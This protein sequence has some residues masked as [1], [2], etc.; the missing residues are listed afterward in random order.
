MVAYSVAPMVYPVSHLRM[1]L[2]SQQSSL[3]KINWML[4][5]D[6]MNARF[7]PV[8]MDRNE[9]KVWIMMNPMPLQLFRLHFKKQPAHLLAMKMFKMVQ[10]RV[11]ASHKWQAL[12][13]KVLMHQDHGLCLQ[14]NCADPCFHT[15]MIDGP[16]VLISCATDDLLVSASCTVY[17]RI[18]ATM[19]GAGWKMHDKGLASFFFGIPICQSDDEWYLD[20][21][22]TLC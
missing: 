13:G 9:S 3:I 2:C 15:G 6:W 14:S 8:P 5:I 4:R 16:A 1:W 17:L 22:S 20:R 11:Y 10:G 18:L 21:S 7:A 19:R 12:I